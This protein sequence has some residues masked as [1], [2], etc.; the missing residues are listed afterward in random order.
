MESKIQINAIVWSSD[1]EAATKYA[2][3]FSKGTKNEAGFF[4]T[5]TDDYILNTYV[6]SSAKSS[7]GIGI[8]TMAD[9][10]L[11]HVEDADNAADAK[12]YL[13]SR[14]GI[15]MKVCLTTKLGEFEELECK[16]I[17]PAELANERDNIVKEAV[18]FE[19]TLVNAFK[20]FD[21]NGN[22]LISTSELITCSKDLGHELNQDDAE[23]ITNSL[24]KDNKGN[25]DFNGFKKWWVSGKSD[26][27]N[28]RRV[29][30]A[31][32]A[33]NKFVKQTSTSFNDYLSN[34]NKDSENIAHTDCE[35]SFNINLH[36]K[37]HFENG[38][39]IYVDVCSGPEAKEIFDCKP[40]KVRNSPV[41]V[42]LSIDMGSAELATETAENLGAML[43]PTM[44]AQMVPQLEAPIQ[45]GA[46]IQMR[47]NQT[48]VVIDLIAT[49]TI[50]DIIIQQQGEF[51]TK[52]IKMGGEM[53]F[54][55][56]SAVNLND[57]V[58]S[59][60]NPFDLVE[61]A[62]NLKLHM[63]SKAFNM[64]SCIDTVCDAIDQ[65]VNEGG[66]PPSIRNFSMATRIATVLRSFDMDFKF[67]PQPIIDCI[68]L[69][70]DYKHKIGEEGFSQLSLS[71]FR[72][73][74]A[75]ESDTKLAR[76]IERM[77]ETCQGALGQATAMKEMIPPE[78]MDIIKA[79]NL[80]KIEL[81]V[82]INTDSSRM[83][84][85]VTLNLPGLNEMR[86]KILED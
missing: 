30:K 20:K 44:L 46:K 66:L 51:N 10:V 31:E 25:I 7:G 15:P 62:L 23:M 73:K 35:Q 52:D 2:E 24:T 85:K 32:L 34:L 39:G 40:E 69:G 56:F 50:A 84:F 3:A 11:V 13:E 1:V 83:S 43:D 33:V 29:V 78:F 12:N 5:N 70:T 68:I 63:A 75:N 74:I 60:L 76:E 49:D 71:E 64:R 58:N 79:I 28:F 21:I 37:N 18:A 17:N 16:Q 9:I 77:R 61:K 41:F 86:G 53:T 19:K 80:E 65:K 14:R 48:K 82:G 55:M 67:D 72:A 8:A 38:V 81:Q 57:V 4:V 47:A 27:S 42:S 45:M 54:H 26:F 36:A 22:G 59:D 6:R